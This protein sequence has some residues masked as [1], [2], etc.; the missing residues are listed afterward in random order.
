MQLD[1]MVLTYQLHPER[2]RMVDVIAH[3]SV[4]III[5]NLKCIVQSTAVTVQRKLSIRKRERKQI[6]LQFGFKCQ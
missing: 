3:Q 2:V 6:G 5:I 1:V 4:K